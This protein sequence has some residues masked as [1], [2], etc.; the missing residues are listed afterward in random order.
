MEEKGSLIQLLTNVKY[1][2]NL[3]IFTYIFRSGQ[4][5]GSAL[6]IILASFYGGF[7]FNLILFG[8]LEIIS[9]MSVGLLIQIYDG[10]K[11][12]KLNLM[13][14]AVFLATFGLTSFISTKNLIFG[15][16]L[17]VALMIIKFSISTVFSVILSLMDAFV[18]LRF[19]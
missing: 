19:Q 8:I 4:I 10:F 18:P 6:T 12:L 1:L 15:I 16:Y 2:V 9:A 3:C 5:A 17:T 13:I 7:Y 14:I 11:L